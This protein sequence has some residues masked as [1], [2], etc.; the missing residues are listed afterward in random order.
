MLVSLF[1]KYIY[2]IIC[3]KLFYNLKTIKYTLMLTK[4]WNQENYKLIFPY[5]I[6]ISIQNK[7]KI[8]E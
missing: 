3:V 7:E 6:S 5:L 8:L 4:Q 2:F 1:W